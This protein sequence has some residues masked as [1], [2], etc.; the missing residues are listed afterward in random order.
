MLHRRCPNCGFSFIF[1]L[2]L[3]EV[4]KTQNPHEMRPMAA[5]WVLCTYNVQG[6]LGSKKPYSLSQ[7][8]FSLNLNFPSTQAALVVLFT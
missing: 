3:K 8:I 1:A 4:K 5:A 7:L 6:V 2:C